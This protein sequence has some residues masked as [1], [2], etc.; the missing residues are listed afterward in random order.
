MPKNRHLAYIALL[1]N[2][3][4]WGAS[5][6]LVKPALD[7]V[8]PYQYLLY[9]YLIASIAF[10]PILIYLLARLKPTLRQIII[11]AVLE[12]T[13]LVLGH[14]V[15][16][17]GLSQTSSLEASFIGISSPIF[18]TLGGV[19]FLKEKEE[20]HEFFGLIIALIGTVIITLE[21]VFKSGLNSLSGSGLGNFLVLG[22]V[23]I[24]TFYNLIAKRVYSNISKPL[25]TGIGLL[26]STP[27]MIV[28]V[29]LTH[30]S[31]SLQNTF[32]DTF[33][34]LSIPSVL[35]ASLYMAIL[36][37]L[38]AIP[39]YIYGLSKIEASEATLFTYLQPLVFI[40][41]AV[42][43]L[44]EAFAPITFVGLILIAPGVILAEH[45]TKTILSE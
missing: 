16:F 37:T 14:G 33:V 13:V 8:S 35:F 39:T 27:L 5:L 34:N 12:T 2:T 15:L 45:R 9:R 22:Y 10:L 17:A 30:P 31:P 41:L 6:P 18:I 43:W 32:V 20:I 4:I 36:G 11:A 38:I 7:L 40:P 42:F 26:A 25:I 1:T 23:L 44:K 19:L 21:P 3:I 29:T 24:W 28:L